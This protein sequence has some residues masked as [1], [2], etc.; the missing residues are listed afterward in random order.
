LHLNV[1][2]WDAQW[3]PEELA[4]KIQL[5]FAG[6][7]IFE[8]RHRRRDGEIRCVEINAVS[9]RLGDHLCLYASA[10][11]IT[12]RK[13][14]EAE[15]EQLI[16]ELQAVLAQVKQLSGLL[17]ICSSCKKIRNDQG[18]WQQ[19]EVYIRD[20]SDVE[21]SHGICPDCMQRLYPDYYQK[22]VGET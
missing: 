8:T 12:E 18:Y 14:A 4:A 3:S 21:F 13:Q 20:H 15:R 10:R 7:T 17:P 16:G 19:V 2:N 1:T 22:T 6:P 11:D 9:A 5:I